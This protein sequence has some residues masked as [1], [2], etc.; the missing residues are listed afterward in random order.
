MKKTNGQPRAKTERPLPC[1]FCG[2]TPKIKLEKDHGP[3]FPEPYY[4]VI[5]PNKSDCG[6]NP[7]AV[8][9]TKEGAI[10]LWNTRDPKAMVMWMVRG[11]TGGAQRGRL[12]SIDIEKL[13]PKNGSYARAAAEFKQH[14]ADRAK[15][16]CCLKEHAIVMQEFDLAAAL[17]DAQKRFMKIA[18][19]A[20]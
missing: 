9:D 10:A 15:I 16:C 1:P 3:E 7:V 19:G 17:R 13:S 6:G 2:A 4:S 12:I 11:N 18:G 20:K 14:A 5:C 8:G